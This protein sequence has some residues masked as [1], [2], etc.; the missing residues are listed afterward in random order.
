[1]G[2]Q[3]LVSKSFLSSVRI[4]VAVVYE[5]RK[6]GKVTANPLPLYPLSCAFYRL[7]PND[8]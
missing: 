6:E 3:N 5:E 1:M 2:R 8:T 4:A 7:R